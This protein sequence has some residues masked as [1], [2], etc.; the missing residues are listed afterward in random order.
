MLLVA[1]EARNKMAGVSEG[2]SYLGIWDCDAFLDRSRESVVEPSGGW[3]WPS[4]SGTNGPSRRILFAGT[5]VVCFGD[6]AG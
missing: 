4:P 3:A 5:I 6:G 2:S 1:R